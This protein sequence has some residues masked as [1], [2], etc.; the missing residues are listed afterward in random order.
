MYSKKVI[1]GAAVA[2][3]LL[4][5][6]AFAQTTDTQA[7]IQSLIAQIQTLQKQLAALMS[8]SGTFRPIGSEGVQG[9][10][11]GTISAVASSSITVQNKDGSKS[12]IVHFTASTTIEVFN[13]SSTPEWQAGTAADLVVGKAV[14]VQGT[15][16]IDSSVNATRIKVGIL[17][18]TAD[19]IK[20]VPPG[21]VQKA[22]C[23]ALKRN[24]GQGSRGEDVRQLQEML[25]ADPELGFNAAAT[26]V[27]G[28]VTARAMMMFQ[29]RSG[30]TPSDDG[31]VGPQTRALLTK[32]CGNAF[33]NMQGMV[34]KTNMPLRDGEG[35][36]PPPPPTSAATGTV[37]N[38]VNVSCSGSSM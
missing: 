30:I 23:L 10:V 31:A 12:V 13:A 37:C 18:A 5:I 16:N 22:M 11:S 32:R 20:D 25:K 15:P 14:G 17:A 9:I 26:G 38:D 7:R 6:V 35:I 2:A 27:F 4:P 24:L 29:K 21:Q 36:P 8:S 28:P 19:K 1:A 33:G 3:A 34:Q